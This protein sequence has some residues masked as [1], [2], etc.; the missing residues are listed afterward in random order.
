MK[1]RIRWD[2]GSHIGATWRLRMTDLY[3][4]A[5]WQCGVMLHFTLTT[6][7]VL[8]HSD[9]FFFYFVRY[10]IEIWTR[11]QNCAYLENFCDASAPF[12]AVATRSR[13][14]TE[15]ASQTVINNSNEPRWANLSQFVTTGSQ[16]CTPYLTMAIDLRYFSSSLHYYPRDAMLARV[17]AMA[18]CLS[19]CLCL[20]LSVCHKSEFYRNGW[21]NRAGFWHGSFFPTFLHCVKRKFGYLQK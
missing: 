2:I 11:A 19:V 6:C 1:P 3:A 13:T 4:A 9:V 18:L 17:L 15:S 7:S 16:L 10:F 12:V 14:R 8:Q 5:N 21:T 20:C